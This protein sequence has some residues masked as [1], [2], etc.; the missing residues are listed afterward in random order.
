MEKLRIASLLLLIYSCSPGNSQIELPE[1]NQL[2]PET[3]SFES[4]NTNH[5]KAFVAFVSGESKSAYLYQIEPAIQKALSRGLDCYVYL[6]SE[7]KVDAIKSIKAYAFPF[8]VIVDS[9]QLFRQLNNES[10]EGYNG[11]IING[12][13]E[14]INSPMI[15]Y[16]KMPESEN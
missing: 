10:I 8:P 3:L 2:N 14:I 6:E 7:S 11:Y 1:L 12:K 9:T 13:N 5:D 16:R 15:G 4:I